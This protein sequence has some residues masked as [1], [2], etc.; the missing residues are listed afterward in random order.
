MIEPSRAENQP[1][2]CHVAVLVAEVLECLGVRP[3]ETVVDGTVGGGGHASQI[4]SELGPEGR[5]FGLDRDSTMLERAGAALDHPGCSLVQASFAEVADVLTAAGQP[6]GSVDAIL[7]DL[8]L[9]SDQLAD[10]ER[11]FGF[12]HGGP[13]DMRFD[14][15][16]GKPAWEWLA[17]VEE[18]ELEECLRLW[19][20]EPES[21]RIAAELVRRR[22]GAPVRT[23]RD[24]SDAVV[25]AVGGRRGRRHPATRVFQAL[26]IAVND[27]L[28]HLE[29][30]LAHGL[31]ESLVA[32]G[33]LVVISFH[34]LEDRIVKRAFRDRDTW[35]AMTGKPIRAT[36][37]EERVNPRSRSARLRAA[38]RT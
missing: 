6:A 24:L 36:P 29:R 14:L 7:L 2:S 18:G 35:K 21:R 13:L 22:R 19:G 33:R 34:S 26:R 32:G 12:D 25:E 23:G 5:L 30:A 3:G 9:S 4:L 10:A 28:V 37:R 27:E 15:S 17:T 1:D 8:G 20:E 38:V 11:G 31:P 16:D